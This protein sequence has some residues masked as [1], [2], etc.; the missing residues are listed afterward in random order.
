MKKLKKSKKEFKPEKMRKRN[1][2]RKDEDLIART[3]ASLL[4][5]NA[6]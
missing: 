1:L 5:Q 3:R 6:Q 4:A 2:Q